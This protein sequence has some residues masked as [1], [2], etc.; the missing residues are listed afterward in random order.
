MVNMNDGVVNLAIVPVPEV[1]AHV[2]P[3]DTD[4]LVTAIIGGL[5]TVEESRLAWLTQPISKAKTKLNQA[6]R[7]IQLRLRL[8][9]GMQGQ[10]SR[11]AHDL[12]KEWLLRPL[13]ARPGSG[14][15]L[16]LP[17]PALQPV[18]LALPDVE[19]EEGGQ[20]GD[21]DDD[22]NESEDSK[23]E[24]SEEESDQEDDDSIAE[25][26][27][28]IAQIEGIEANE[29]LKVENE[30]LQSELADLKRKYYDQGTEFA[31]TNESLNVLDEDNTQLR[32]RVARLESENRDLLAEVKRL[33][34][35][36]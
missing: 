20:Y 11:E 29:N 1:E 9:S 8:P 27:G 24:G 25:L 6:V 36:S 35:G 19:V 14:P 33:K 4:E 32:L 21:D 26:E 13:Q 28:Q 18:P 10:W 16:A 15:M 22:D 23:E 34:S 12:L 30:R 2:A 3:P 7:N 31:D 5:V 17:A